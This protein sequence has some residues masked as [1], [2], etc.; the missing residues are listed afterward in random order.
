MPRT[1]RAA[2][3]LL[4]C[5][6]AAACAVRR[7]GP[8]PDPSQVWAAYLARE[9]QLQAAPPEIQLR[10]SLWY[11][12]PKRSNRT[13]VNLWGSLDGPLR[14][15]LNASMGA[16][17]GLF[18]EDDAGWTA[19]YPQSN[20]AFVS[21]SANG[22]ASGFANGHEGAGSGVLGARV[23]FSLHDVAR[24]LTGRVL[25]L[26]GSTARSAA[27]GEDGLTVFTLDASAAAKSLT[28]DPDGRPVALSGG[29]T[30][31]WSIAFKDYGD[32]VA[33]LPGEVVM[34]LSEGRFARLILKSFSRPAKPWTES[35]MRLEIPPDVVVKPAQ[36]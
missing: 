30:E 3:I 19:Y 24:L 18:R 7:A 36:P 17:I 1:L 27:P 12:T 8:P 9:K 10:A 5:L 31:P 14:V 20:E 29:T 25:P 16:S 13:L 22:T 4:C 21:V 11:T 35:A 34:D 33:D 15:D 2:L 32:P 28:L 26:T 23:P 6:G